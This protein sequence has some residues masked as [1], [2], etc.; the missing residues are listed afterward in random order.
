MTDPADGLVAPGTEVTPRRRNTPSGTGI[1]STEA[2]TFQYDL[3]V[4][5]ADADEEFVREHLLPAVGLAPER[6]MLSSAL[7]LGAFTLNELERGVQSSQCTVVVL[8]PALATD[9]L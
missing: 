6:V 4:V 8:S 2:V 7:A 3:F 9:G 1:A 5:H